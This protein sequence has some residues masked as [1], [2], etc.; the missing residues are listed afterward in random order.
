LPTR[1]GLGYNARAGGPAILPLRVL[2]ALGGA[3]MKEINAKNDGIEATN[4]VEETWSPLPIESNKYFLIA[5]IETIVLLTRHPIISAKRPAG[6]KPFNLI[7][8][9]G[10]NII[11]LAAIQYYFLSASGSN[12]SRF[13]SIAFD[14][15]LFQGINFVLSYFLVCIFSWKYWRPISVYRIIS[16]SSYY[17]IYLIN[18]FAIV[19]SSVMYCMFS[20]ASMRKSFSLST[21]KSILVIYIAC[22]F[23]LL[24]AFFSTL[25]S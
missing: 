12:L 24:V 11:L 14:V 4:N 3:V 19:F 1:P 16:Y 6:D 5:F 7:G 13:I 9:H 10:I 22:Q 21:F 20:V 25:P 8:F 2:T 15:F 17:L 18:P 23:T